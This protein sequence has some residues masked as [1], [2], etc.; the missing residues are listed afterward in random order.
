[1][2]HLDSVLQDRLGTGLLSKYSLYL[3]RN[4]VF[5]NL[6][7]TVSLFND[8]MEERFVMCVTL[9]PLRDNPPTTCRFLLYTDAVPPDSVKVEKRAGSEDSRVKSLRPLKFPVVIGC[10]YPDSLTGF[11]GNTS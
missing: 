5:K 11:S 10:L 4:S 7:K 2:V 9:S 3:Q 8:L 1:M 6:T